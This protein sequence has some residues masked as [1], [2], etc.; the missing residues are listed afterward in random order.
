MITLPK[1]ER[2]KQNSYAEKNAEGFLI[3]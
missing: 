1:G 3:A 2:G